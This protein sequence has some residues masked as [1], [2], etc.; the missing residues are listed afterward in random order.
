MWWNDEKYGRA[1]QNGSMAWKTW[2]DGRI[3]MG[4]TNEREGEKVET[5]GKGMREK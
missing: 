3:R 5:R 2:R 1:R 4:R